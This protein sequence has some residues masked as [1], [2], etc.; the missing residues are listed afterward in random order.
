[1][2]TDRARKPDSLTIV[3][4]SP[5]AAGGP[6]TININESE[7]GR[8]AP[9]AS[10]S[11]STRSANERR[12]L[13]IVIG[14]AWSAPPPGAERHEFGI[15][16]DENSAAHKL[17]RALKTP[18]TQRWLS[19]WGD[20]RG[21]P[22]I[23][24]FLT[25][26]QMDFGTRW[27][28]AIPL[29][30][31]TMWKIAIGI[32]SSDAA[33]TAHDKAALLS[34]LRRNAGDGSVIEALGWLPPAAG[35]STRACKESKTVSPHALLEQ[36]ADIEEIVPM[37]PPATSNVR[38]ARRRLLALVDRIDRNARRSHG[39]AFAFVRCKLHWLLARTLD[40]GGHSE[41]ASGHLKRAFAL[42]DRM[43]HSHHATIEF[44]E[45]QGRLML[46]RHRIDTQAAEPLRVVNGP[47]PVP[48][49]WSSSVSSTEQSPIVQVLAW[50]AELWRHRVAIEEARGDA[51]S[52]E[53]VL[54]CLRALARDSELLRDTRGSWWDAIAARF[55]AEQFV[56]YVC[57]ALAECYRLA[58]D[59]ARSMLNAR[60]ALEAFE[61]AQRELP[62]D[63]VCPVVRNC[64]TI[65]LNKQAELIVDY[66]PQR[67]AQAEKYIVQ[68]L[69]IGRELVAL[70]PD[71]A[72]YGNSHHVARM[73]ALRVRVARSGSTAEIL[74]TVQESYE[75]GQR[76]SDAAPTNRFLLAGVVFPLEIGAQCCYVR[77]NM[78]ACDHL[79]SILA[80]HLLSAAAPAGKELRPG[81]AGL[82]AARLDSMGASQ[83]AIELLRRVDP[84]DTWQRIEW[85]REDDR[86]ALERL[87]QG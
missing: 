53:V 34:Q 67:L 81:T 14:F 31:R 17:Y 24:T 40:F 28:V 7:A 21:Q 12:V 76:H 10:V 4:G 54:G 46:V 86:N 83:D 27:R 25:C 51:S 63:E 85:L 77:S 8:S 69:R 20:L 38:E 73:I 16:G 44:R 79:C 84:T 45:L 49:S 37:A 15:E 48:G 66:F 32:D 58:G 1:M 2:G 78:Q 35:A 13:A 59:E 47:G 71:N 57:D 65:P 52:L 43:E 80:V 72:V 74:Q 26:T 42:M 33:P 55:E 39:P 60:E 3:L 5:N 56:G 30:Q 23:T 18:V 41:A 87:T 29:T 75:D 62:I 11:T 68:S 50:R 64:L 36:L 19:A 22:F 9:I 61:R 82:V 70:D 6:W